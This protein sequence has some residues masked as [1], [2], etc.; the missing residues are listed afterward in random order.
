MKA[1]EEFCSVALSS[2]SKVVLVISPHYSNNAF[3]TRDLEAVQAIARKYE[4]PLLDYSQKAFFLEKG[5]LF[6][7]HYHLNEKGG[8]IF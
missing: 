7:D 4:V 1:L 6:S 8:D 3:S 2:G 5:F